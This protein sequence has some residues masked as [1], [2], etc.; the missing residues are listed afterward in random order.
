MSTEE[1]VKT[2]IAGVCEQMPGT[3]PIDLEKRTPQGAKVREAIITC[4]RRIAKETG[5]KEFLSI[6]RTFQT[7]MDVKPASDFDT[8]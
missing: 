8:K 2:L 3:R 7:Q 1:K 4:A 6:A 5:D